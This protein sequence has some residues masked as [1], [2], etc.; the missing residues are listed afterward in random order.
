MPDTRHIMARNTAI[1]HV[2]TR[3]LILKSDLKGHAHFQET[4]FIEKALYLM[5]VLLSFFTEFSFIPEEDFTD[6]HHPSMYT[7]KP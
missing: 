3:Q 7:E 2:Y 1:T 5:H 6:L 4:L